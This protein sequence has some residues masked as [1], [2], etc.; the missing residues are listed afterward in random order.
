MAVGTKNRNGKKGQ[1]ALEYLMTYG[2]ALLIIL[3]IMAVLVYLVKPQQVEACNVAL[4]FQ[5]EPDHYKIKGDGNLT[6]RLNNM[7]TT[8]YVITETKCGTKTTA[9]SNV[10]LSPG[11]NVILYFNCTNKVTGT[12][13]AGKDVFKDDDDISF[14]YY[15]E[16]NAD[17]T[18]V[19]L[20]DIVVKYS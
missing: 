8:R 2:W 14:V 4:P 13:V 7:G 17:F 19:Q 18:K 12:H 16:D 11:S 9:L 15:P 3:A 1:A 10:V 5:C 6:L 20:I